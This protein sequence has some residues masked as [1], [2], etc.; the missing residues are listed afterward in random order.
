MSYQTP[1]DYP[2]LPSVSIPSALLGDD[3]KSFRGGKSTIRNLPAASG[4]STVENSSILFNIPAEPY[5]MY[6]FFFSLF[7]GICNSI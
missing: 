7:F 3:L 1:Q 2:S 4:S 6:C 5:G